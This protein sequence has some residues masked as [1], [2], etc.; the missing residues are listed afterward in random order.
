MRLFSRTFLR[1]DDIEAFRAASSLDK[2]LALWTCDVA[3]PIYVLPRTGKE[4]LQ[5]DVESLFPLLAGVRPQDFPE[6]RLETTGIMDPLVFPKKGHH[7]P[8]GM[9]LIVSWLTVKV[10]V[11]VAML[12]TDQTVGSSVM[13]ARVVTASGVTWASFLCSHAF[14]YASLGG[15]G[16][17]ST[18]S[19]SGRGSGRSTSA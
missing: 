6:P 13:N 1:L 14:G 17:L 12:R 10:R 4:P 9:V 15:V 16:S 7:S 11:R 2:S 19:P 3:L 5:Y 8:S 18:G